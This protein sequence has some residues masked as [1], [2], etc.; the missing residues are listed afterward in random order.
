MADKIEKIH[1]NYSEYSYFDLLPGAEQLRYFFDLFEVQSHTSGINLKQFFHDVN[2]Q[3]DEPRDNIVINHEIPDHYNRV[4][5]LIDDE[6]LMIE[7][8]SLKSI[9]TVTTKFME[10]GY[11]LRRD[12][13]TEKM[14]KKDKTARY[15]RVFYI[16]DQTTGI[17]L[18]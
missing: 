15:I 9:R 14:F 8:N 12:H 10:A 7:A 17:C 11:M 6:F 2:T 18:N 5:V 13:K 3:L 1:V 16:I 4:D